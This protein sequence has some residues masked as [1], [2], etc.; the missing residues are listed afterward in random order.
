MLWDEF[1]LRGGGCGEYELQKSAESCFKIGAGL[2]L[3]L[4]VNN[5]LRGQKVEVR[6]GGRFPKQKSRGVFLCRL[7]QIHMMICF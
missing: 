4:H 6:E 7:Q 2:N 1:W 5:N 3:K